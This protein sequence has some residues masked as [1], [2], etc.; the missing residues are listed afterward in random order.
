MEID[1]NEVELFMT[2]IKMSIKKYKKDLELISCGFHVYKG[3]K[4]ETIKSNIQFLEEK[5]YKLKF[6]LEGVSN[7]RD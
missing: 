6:A 3:E 4:R 2:L 7:G 5:Y 1:S